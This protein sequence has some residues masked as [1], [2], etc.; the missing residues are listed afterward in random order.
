MTGR[1]SRDTLLFRA[2]ITLRARGG[3]LGGGGLYGCQ[4]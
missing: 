1:R 4:D 2:D 3:G